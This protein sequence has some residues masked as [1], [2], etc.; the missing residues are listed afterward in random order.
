MIDIFNSDSF[1]TV[2]LTSAINVVPNMYG[3]LQQLG[4][5]PDKGRRTRTVALERKNGVLNLLPSRPVGGPASKGTTA[6]RS[7]KNL[8]IPHF[9]HED[10]VLAE[11]VQG[12][13]AFGTD[14]QLQ[15]AQDLIN[16]KL[17]EH[18]N[19]HNI[20]KEFL[21]WGAIKGLILDADGSTLLDVFAEFAV[22][23]EVED[24]AFSTANE[25]IAQ[26][27]RTLKR[28]METNAMGVTYDHIHVMCSPGW[29]DS[30]IGHANVEKF[31][32]TFLNGRTLNNDQRG[33]FPFQDVVFEEH[34]GQATDLAGT[35][36]KFIPDNEAIAFPVGTTGLFETALAPADFMETVNTIGLPYYAKLERM[37]FDRGVE[38][39][40][41]QNP[42]PICQRP[43]LLVRLTKS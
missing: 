27:V 30:F 25:N 16:D 19:K 38:I 15:G 22:T 29:F 31:Y 34:S 40:T 6:K 18:A 35:V 5:F 4:V 43:E 8:T 23:Q 7:L 28:Y 41:Q 39:H 14:N 37:K 32:L 9:P 17:I 42:L 2:E 3:R 1:G 33:G 10:V 24:F 20:T 26:L 12:V 13:R 21:R 36:R 11:D